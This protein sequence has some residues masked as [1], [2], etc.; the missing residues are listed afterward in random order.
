MSGGFM[1]I[2]VTPGVRAAQA[3]MGADHLWQDFNGHREFNRFT[4]YETA[5]I[6]SRDSFYMATVS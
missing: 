5:F 1:D 3:K 4:E 2:A 6:C